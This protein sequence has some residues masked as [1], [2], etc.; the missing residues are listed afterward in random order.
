MIIPLQH[1]KVASARPRRSWLLSAQAR[2]RRL[3][4]SGRLRQPEDQAAVATFHFRLL[5]GSIVL[6]LISD[7]VS[8]HIAGSVLTSLIMLYV[9]S[10]KLTMRRWNETRERRAGLHDRS[11]HLDRCVDDREGLGL[12]RNLQRFNLEVGECKTIAALE[13]LA[14]ER[15]VAIARSAAQVQ[16]AGPEARTPVASDSHAFYLPLSGDQ[17]T[18]TIFRAQ[19]ELSQAQYRELDYL[20]VLVG[21]Q[22]ARLLGAARLARQQAALLALWQVAGILRSALDRQEALD[23]VCGRMTAALE[24]N[25]LALLA[26]DERQSVSILLISRGDRGQPAPRL[27][28]AQLRVAAEAL[29]TE[30]ALIRSEGR[31]ALTCLPI[32]LLGDTPVILAAHGEQLDAAA[33]ALLMLFGEMIVERLARS[34]LDEEPSALEGWLPIGD[35]KG[36]PYTASFRESVLV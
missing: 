10:E 15:A 26:P 23:E 9:A 29:R 22:A 21:A 12:A 19:D 2:P 20:A 34:P 8:W 4:T 28:G 18:L 31:Q 36:V 3:L 32:R 24:L 16:L 30:S 6:L 35:E 25:W 27:T 5:L 14:T 7:L 33:Q 1:D 13:R 11:A 17:G